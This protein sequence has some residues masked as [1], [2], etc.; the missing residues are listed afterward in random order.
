MFWARF[1]VGL[2][3]LAL[4][5]PALAWSGVAMEFSNIDT[6]FV[7]GAAG[8]GAQT[9]S[10]AFQIEDGP[11]DGL[12][13]GAGIGYLDLRLDGAD[14]APARK[15]DGQ[16]VGVYLRHALPVGDWLALHARL[17]LRLT[18]GNAV[19]VDQD[20]SF[21]WTSTTIDLGLAV[22]VGR[23]RLVPFVAWRDIDGDIS[24]EDG[25]AFFELESARSQGL[26]IDTLLGDGGF[27]RVELIGGEREGAMLT[28]ARQY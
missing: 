26:R 24:G 20:A 16:H 1:S 25:S 14:G 15:F 13:V 7:F 3:G 21:D 19:G 4:S 18:S 17:D 12:R 22:T 6:T 9:G 11:A 23:L 8:R 27:V 10:I 2:C 28:F 5:L